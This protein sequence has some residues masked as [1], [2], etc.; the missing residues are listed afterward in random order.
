M[1]KEEFIHAFEVLKEHDE[2]AIE[3]GRDLARHFL[4][5]YSVVKY[6]GELQDSYIKLLAEASGIDENLISCL[7]YEGGGMHYY[8]E[9]NEIQYN[10][11]TAEDLWD[12][13]KLCDHHDSLINAEE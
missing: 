7:L 11:V 3:I 5:G 2:T 12:F 9:N 1:K 4:D 13:C 8:G 6:G 10:V